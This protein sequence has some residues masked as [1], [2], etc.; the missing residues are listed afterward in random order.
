MPDLVD[1]LIAACSFTSNYRLISLV[2]NSVDA[3]P[4]Y[5]STAVAA[6]E[7]LS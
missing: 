5:P 6:A 1:I 3:P 4:K 2:Q 7:V